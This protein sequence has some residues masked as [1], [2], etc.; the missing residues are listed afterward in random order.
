M[1][2]FSFIII[3]F[4]TLLFSQLSAYADEQAIL[5]LSPQLTPIVGKNMNVKVLEY[6]TAN[7]SNLGIK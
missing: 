3:V 2:C 1:K 7:Q 6:C 4:A 5:Y